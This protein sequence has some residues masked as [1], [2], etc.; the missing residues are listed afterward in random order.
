MEIE[1]SKSREEGSTSEGFLQCWPWREHGPLLIGRP[2]RP[3]VFKVP[4]GLLSTVRQTEYWHCKPHRGH[5]VS[6]GTRLESVFYGPGLFRY[7]IIT[8]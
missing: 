8:P 1:V 7:N 4:K 2:L 3:Y 6:G 5:G